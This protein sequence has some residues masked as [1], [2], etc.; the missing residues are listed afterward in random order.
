MNWV[1]NHDPRIFTNCDSLEPVTAVFRFS[2]DTSF[3]WTS[4]VGDGRI[5]KSLRGAVSGLYTLFAS[6]V[7]GGAIG[8]GTSQVVVPHTVSDTY[9]TANVSHPYPRMRYFLAF[10]YSS[11]SINISLAPTRVSLTRPSIS[12]G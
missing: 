7:L 4:E 8:L 6:S 5:A 11:L 1:F 10:R 12:D 9:P 2:R 3:Q